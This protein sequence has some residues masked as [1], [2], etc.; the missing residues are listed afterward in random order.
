MVPE[1]GGVVIKKPKT[2]RQS[3]DVQLE[4]EARMLEDAGI[5]TERRILCL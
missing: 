1:G 3:K 4:G 5:E 2:K